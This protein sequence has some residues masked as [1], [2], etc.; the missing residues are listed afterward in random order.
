MFFFFWKEEEKWPW[1]QMC[2]SSNFRKGD[3]SHHQWG[4]YATC[5]VLSFL[6]AYLKMGHE[7]Q[8]NLW[9]CWMHGEREK[10]EACLPLN[11]AKFSSWLIDFLGFSAGP[12]S[13]SRNP[14]YCCC[15]FLKGTVTQANSGSLSKRK[16]RGLTVHTCDCIAGYFLNRTC[17]HPS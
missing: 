3:G 15:F 5:Q 16:G 17:H 1:T 12:D 4:D 6:T 7:L 2:F 13:G 14:K 9:T 11:S 8:I 10:P